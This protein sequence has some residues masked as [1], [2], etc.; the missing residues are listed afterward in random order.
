M[1]KRFFQKIIPVASGM[2]AAVLFAPVSASA[3]DWVTVPV[4]PVSV[5]FQHPTLVSYPVVTTPMVT[6]QTVAPTVYVQTT[7]PAAVVPS[8]SYVADYPV[9]PSAYYVGTSYMGVVWP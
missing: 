9:V 7:M 5:L 8:Y 1:K 2:L 6:V 4:N 3:H